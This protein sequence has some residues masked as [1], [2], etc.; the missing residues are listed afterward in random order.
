MNTYLKEWDYRQNKQSHSFCLI[1]SIYKNVRDEATETMTRPGRSASP[2]LHLGL[3]PSPREQA[4]DPLWACSRGGVGLPVWRVGPAGI[5]MWASPFTVMSHQH[6]RPAS[7]IISLSRR[8]VKHCRSSRKA[9]L[10][11][12]QALS[13]FCLLLPPFAHFPPVRARSSASPCPLFHRPS[14]A[15]KGDF[16]RT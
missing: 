2:T 8:K 14:L 13:L 7:P 12:F 6:S 1:A 4:P 16:A 11:L 5:G 10:P 15:S 3:L 9:F